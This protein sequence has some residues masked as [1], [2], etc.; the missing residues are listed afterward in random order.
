[1]SRR[2]TKS[3]GCPHCGEH[4]D[5]QMYTTINVTLDPKLRD[6]V[7]DETLFA[8][9]CPHCGYEAMLLNPFLY[10]DMEHKFMIYLRP[11][12]R[13]S[14]FSVPDTERQFPELGDLKKR[15][16]PDINTLK[17]KILLFEEELDDRASELTKLALGRALSKRL[18]EPIQAGYFCLLDRETDQVGYSFFIPKRQ[19]PIYQNT[20]IEV[21]DRSMDI[22]RRFGGILPTG[23][24]IIDGAWASETLQRYHNS[25]A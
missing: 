9:V 20:K 18:H 3:V 7:M 21:Y 19:E 10:H 2:T 11:E 6:R 15:L 1:M 16:A 24:S 23:F 12:Q 8:W 14:F 5:T 25:M 22:A 13:E 4:S 17:E